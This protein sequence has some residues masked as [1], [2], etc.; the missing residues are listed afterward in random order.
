MKVLIIV[1]LA[2]AAWDCNS[3][4]PETKPVQNEP[5][6]QADSGN[7]FPITSYIKGQLYEIKQKGLTP[8]KYITVNNLTDSA[9][10]PVDSMPA[11]IAEFLTP[12]IDTA[13]LK[14]W[15]TEEEFFDQTL[16]VVTFTYSAKYNSPDSIELRNWDLYIDKETQKVKRIYLLKRKSKNNIMQLT[17]QSD[18][19][20]KMVYLEETG[21]ETRVIKEEKITWVY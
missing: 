18:Q 15:F 11:A 20:C 12:V 8:K 5:K 7:F 17:W 4:A 16:D 13:N 9:W 10:V 2:F 21:K 3:P 14:P 19:F 6:E 1:F